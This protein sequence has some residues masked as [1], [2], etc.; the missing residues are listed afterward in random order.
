[1]KKRFYLSL[2]TAMA[3]A[4]TACAEAAGNNSS[5]SQLLP[6]ILK[7]SESGWFAP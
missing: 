5:R 1:M 4:L 2:I 7:P 3:L 6:A